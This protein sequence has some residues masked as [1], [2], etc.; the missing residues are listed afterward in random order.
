MGQDPFSSSLEYSIARVSEGGILMVSNRDQSS[1]ALCLH[2]MNSPMT[3][4]YL[5]THYHVHS[6][7]AIAGNMGPEDPSKRKKIPIVF[8]MP[9]FRILQDDSKNV[10]LK[11]GSKVP[12]K[13]KRF[14]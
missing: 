4:Q 12:Q 7:Q 6:K 14:F 8:L 13:I 9:N 2:L 10:S 3:I 11:I 5:L 1:V